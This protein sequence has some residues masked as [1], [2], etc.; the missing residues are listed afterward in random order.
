MAKA[1]ILVKP[2]EKGVRV[3]IGGAVGMMLSDDGL[4]VDPADAEVKK[5]LREG[6]LRV[7]GGRHVEHHKRQK[8]AAHKSSAAKGRS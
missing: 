6:L 5:L 1:S 7:E 2:F 8:S 3:W 4:M